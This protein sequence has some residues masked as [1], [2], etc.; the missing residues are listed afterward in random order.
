MA[1]R[2]FAGTTVKIDSV[3]VAKIT[4]WG[5]D[6]S[7]AETD[8]TGSEDVVAGTEILQTKMEPTGISTTIN[9]AGIEVIGDTGQSDVETA[10]GEGTEVVITQLYNDGTGKDY[11]GFL[12]S[13]NQ[14]GSVG[15]AV[16]KF[17]ATFRV[18]S[19]AAA[20]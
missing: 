12:T 2:R 8:V 7:T 18:N 10:F 16:Y 13:Y 5:R 20:A 3:T 6:S 1:N 4:S 15:D 9:F 19:I 11:T 17:T 14:S